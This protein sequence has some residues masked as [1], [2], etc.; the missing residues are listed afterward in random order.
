MFSGG[1]GG[2]REASSRQKKHRGFRRSNMARAGS[3]R[4][5]PIEGG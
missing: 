5:D 2:S 3:P 4:R 1:S